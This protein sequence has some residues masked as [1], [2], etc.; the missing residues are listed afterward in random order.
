MKLS[1]AK[2]RRDARRAAWDR[3]DWPKG[4]KRPGSYKKP[5][6]AGVGRSHTK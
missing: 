3:F 6:P 5:W 1:K 4:F 2:G